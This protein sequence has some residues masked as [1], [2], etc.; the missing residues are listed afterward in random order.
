MH[1]TA[2]QQHLVMGATLQQLP[3]VAAAVAA[4]PQSKPRRGWCGGDSC[5]CC[6]LG[7][8]ARPGKQ[9]AREGGAVELHAMG[10]RTNWSKLTESRSWATF[11]A[12][13][14]SFMACDRSVLPTA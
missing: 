2:T 7:M 6:R 10:E 5:S 13:S 3:R 11:H 9:A 12:S 4:Q 14:Y 8:R 1:D